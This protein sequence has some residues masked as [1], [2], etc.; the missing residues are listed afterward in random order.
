MAQGS[1]SSLAKQ[2]VIY[3]I[4]SILGRLLNYL[5]VPLY[6]RLFLPAEAAVYVEFYAYAAIFLVILTYGMETAF[7][8]FINDKNLNDQERVY[9]TA[10]SSILLTS[11]FFILI[12]SI[13]SNN[14]ASGLGYV[15]NGKY[16]IFFAIIAGA[17]AVSSI[18]FAYLRSK[19]KAITF[20]TIR[21]I[22][23]IINVFLNILFL[24]IIPNLY[25]NHPD[26]QNFLSIFT[27]GTPWI[28]YIFVA[29]L[30]TSLLNLILL[31]PYYKR[32]KLRIDK[33]LWVI[34]LKY[35][36]P[37][38]ILGLSGILN[39]NIDRILLKNLLPPDIAM[40]QVGVYGMVFKFSVIMSLALQAFRYA[41]DPFFFEQSTEQDAKKTY[42][43]VMNYFVITL[44]LIYALT[45]LNMDYVKYFVGKSYFEGLPVVNILLLSQLFLGIFYN[46]SIWY[47]LT[48][49][50]L[51]G[52][53]VSISG[54]AILIILNIILIPKIGY[55]GSAWANLICNFTIAVASYL[56]SQK[57]Y[58]V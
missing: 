54:T 41:A 38:L 8:R 37:L 10:F 43:R 28:G 51:L 24:V 4:S 49:K 20:A 25:N 55:V 26:L 18:P 1:V 23:I 47:K 39:N 31:F 44:V 19:G 50:T 21:I 32:V 14:I 3:G 15:G 40:H 53:I 6:S 22:N 13:F 58:P 11:S 16:V 56:L 29:N 2:T 34:M 9:S 42:A 12:L 45:M 7:F 33:H 27:N 36:L 5:L 52:A 57:Y 17:D 46:L 48:D 35:A 30:I